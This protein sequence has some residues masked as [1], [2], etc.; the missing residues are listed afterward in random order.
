VCGGSEVYRQALPYTQRIYLTVIDY[1]FSEVD[2]YFPM[3]DLSEWR[4]TENIKNKA[5]E[6]N[7]FDHYFV[8][9]EKKINMN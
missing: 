5:D 2:T 4:V 7:P 9:Y 3:I 1:A 8:T 6:N